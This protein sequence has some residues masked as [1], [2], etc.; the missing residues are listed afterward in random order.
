MTI[1]E[2]ST[3]TG[4]ET[5]KHVVLF[6]CLALAIASGSAIAEEKKQPEKTSGWSGKFA[7][8]LNSLTGNTNTG[9]ANASF[10]AT[11]ASK[12]PLTHNVDASASYGDRS[13]GRG[14]DRIETRNTKA[15]AYKAEYALDN[16]KK[17]ALIGYLSYEDDNRAKLDSHIMVGAGYS[18]NLYKDKRHSLSGSIGAGYL[19]VKFTD[20]TEGYD[21]PAGR[22]SLAYKLNLTDNI[23]LN[24]GVVVLASDTNT[25]IRVNSA[26]R[27]KLT[28]R[29]SVALTNK[30]TNNT[31][32]PVTALDKTDNET[33]VN[34]VFNF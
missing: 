21:E 19:S 2:S 17:S 3:L 10:D 25:L 26:L 32:K 4:N 15:A 34:L 9:L 20:T 11:Y 31:F 12:T 33:G 7:I 28:E 13:A 6:A 14:K 16:E 24:E 1:A 23:S 22:V 29:V 5:S 8:G 27:Y 30:T 18:R